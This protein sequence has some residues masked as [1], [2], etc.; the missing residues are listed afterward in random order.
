VHIKRN[1]ILAAS[2]L[3]W[4]LSLPLIYEAPPVRQL[5]LIADVGNILLLCFA[6]EVTA[7]TWLKWAKRVLTVYRGGITPTR[8]GG[9]QRIRMNYQHPKHETDTPHFDF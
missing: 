2:A 3:A 9:V 8:T 6:R 7:E 1:C 5:S 4:I